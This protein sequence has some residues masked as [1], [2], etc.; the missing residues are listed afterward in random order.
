M[1]ATWTSSPVLAAAVRMLLRFF[2]LGVLAVEVGEQDVQS[3]L[4]IQLDISADSPFP[5]IRNESSRL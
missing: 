3:A 2:G 1:R 4:D 5:R